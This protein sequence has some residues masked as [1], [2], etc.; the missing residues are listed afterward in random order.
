MLENSEEVSI[1]C[2][3]NYFLWEY[4]SVDLGGRNSFVAIF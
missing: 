1:I 4:Y 3:N 2:N